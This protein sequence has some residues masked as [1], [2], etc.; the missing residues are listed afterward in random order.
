MAKMYAVNDWT[1]TEDFLTKVAIKKGKL[2]KGGEPDMISTAKIILVDWQKGDLPFYSLPEGEV[3]KYEGRD[4]ER[5][6]KT[7]DHIK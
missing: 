2:R 3:D 7:L 1:D 6:L 4:R 5:D